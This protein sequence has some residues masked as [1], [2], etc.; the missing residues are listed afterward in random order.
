MTQEN[1]NFIKSQLTKSVLIDIEGNEYKVKTVNFN[2]DQVEFVTGRMGLISLHEDIALKLAESGK[3]KNWIVKGFEVEEDEFEGLEELQEE[4]EEKENSINVENILTITDHLNIRE[5]N[6]NINENEK[7]IS[8]FFDS[9]SDAYN[10]TRWLDENYYIGNNEE[11]IYTSYGKEDEIVFINSGDLEVVSKILEYKEKKASEVEE[12]TE[13]NTGPEGI[14]DE[15]ILL[16][17]VNDLEAALKYNNEQ[18]GNQVKVM[19]ISRNYG[20]DLD[21]WMM[22]QVRDF[23]GLRKLSDKDKEAFSRE[24]KAYYDADNQPKHYMAFWHADTFE[25][26]HC[27]GEGECEIKHKDVSWFTTDKGY[28]EDEVEEIQRLDVGENWTSTEYGDKH[29]ITRVQ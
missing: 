26:Y 24:L 7:E 21:D 27:A 19:T 13:P 11:K 4:M 10:F 25:V 2:A 5:E 16:E 9:D 28:T 15:T 6:V 17:L 23:S 20:F 22:F 8:I 14:D 29:I 1:Q 12:I 18:V 3:S